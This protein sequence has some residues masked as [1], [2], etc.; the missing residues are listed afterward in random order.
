MFTIYLI[1][2]DLSQ[3]KRWRGGANKINRVLLGRD[4][5]R[6]GGLTVYLPSIDPS[7]NMRRSVGGVEL[8]ELIVSCLGGD[9]GTGGDSQSVYRL[10]GVGVLLNQAHS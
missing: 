1:S 5:V 9:S 4:R 2:N 7:K 6:G 10:L 8:M 3:D